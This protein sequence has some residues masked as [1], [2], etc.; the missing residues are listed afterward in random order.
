MTV[1]QGYS[2]PLV[3]QAGLLFLALLMVAATMQSMSRAATDR[4][5]GAAGRLAEAADAKAAR[6]SRT[7]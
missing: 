3:F 5:Y 4:I 7:E 1:W 6:D 2:V